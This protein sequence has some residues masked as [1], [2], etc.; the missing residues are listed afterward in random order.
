MK[1]VT[2]LDLQKRKEQGQPITMVTAYDYGTAELVDAAGID[3]ILV[4]DSVGMVVMGLDST[5]PV[6]MDDML[7]HCR[8]VARG[9]QRAFLVGDMPFLSYQTGR[10]EAI[11]N[12]G[13]LLKEAGMEAVKLEGGQEMAEIITAVTHAGIPVMGHI[14]LTPQSV[15]QLG[16]Y[17]IQGKTAVAAQ[18]LLDDALALEAAGCFSLVLEAVPAPVAS[19]ISQR[20][21]IPTI[22]IGAGPGCDGQV[23]VY[24]DMLG[25]FDKLQPRFVKRYADLRQTI[26]DALTSYRDEVTAGQFPSEKHTYPMDTAEYEAFMAYLANRDG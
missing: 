19:A 24:H 6:T 11:Y 12:A 22:G 5:V 20:L 3:V 1:K 2:I 23:L 17:R 25:L 10:Q 21:R 7:H 16:G 9:S 13:R 15:S 14:G 18:K 26:I 8:M 4:G